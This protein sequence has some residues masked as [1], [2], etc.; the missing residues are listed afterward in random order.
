MAAI[1]VIAALLLWNAYRNT[2]GALSIANI[3]IVSEDD[4]KEMNLLFKIIKSMP[5][6]KGL[7]SLENYEKEDAM[8]E[9]K[10]GNLQMIVEIPENFV[11]D[12]N[13]MQDSSL[14]LYVPKGDILANNRIYAMLSS[15][16]SLMVTTES[17]ICSMYDGMEYYSYDTTV[18]EMEDE[19]F[20][21]YINSFLNR[22]DFIDIE[23]ISAYGN[24]ESFL[25]YGISIIVFVMAIS[26][27]FLLKSY[28]RNILETERILARSVKDKIV[29]NILKI[30]CYS[31]PYSILGSVLYSFF[32]FISGGL[33]YEIY[34]SSAAYITIF[35]I[36]ITI[37]SFVHLFA[38]LLGDKEGREMLYALIVSFVWIVSLSVAI[39]STF[40]V[41]SLS[42]YALLSAGCDYRTSGA[43]WG[44]LVY[45]VIFMVLAVVFSVVHL[46][47]K[48]EFK[49]FKGK[50]FGSNNIYLNWLRLKL[51]LNLKSF[52]FW[53][54]AA[55]I[56]IIILTTHFL[57]LKSE[58]SN[59][60]IYISN[61]ENE[62]LVDCI[63]DSEYSG[64]EYEPVRNANNMKKEILRGEALAGI[65]NRDGKIILYAP[66]GSYSAVILRE[67]IFP[68][69]FNKQSPNLLR[70]YL[71]GIGL[72]D[73]DEEQKYV[74]DANK[75]LSEDF[76]VS[77]FKINEV[78]DARLSG[79]NKKNVT[80]FVVTVMIVMVFIISVTY[81][82]KTN[83]GFLNSKPIFVRILLV[84]ESG[85]V[86]SLLLAV[87][88]LAALFI[89]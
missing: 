39:N 88:A 36:G 4:S 13:Y 53:L 73:D 84:L 64:F 37:S 78:S 28:S 40:L 46:E 17:A 14:T 6:V 80:G 1:L 76:K 33:G 60:V 18:S 54:E 45:L 81:E 50:I 19:V 11:T 74:L 51:K 67:L 10:K 68:Y 56:I 72:S 87:T 89:I 2:D 21:I 27:A 62:E 41:T 59:R 9:L 30:I 48:F 63:S 75:R 26:G 44:Q 7:C 12:L 29:L 24:F 22:E 83:K 70:G 55:V 61:N 71:N 5:A 77:I 25:Y 58:D 66:T 20:R 23:Y 35:L 85:V 69:M 15:V 31:I 8:E 57:V 42:R 16:E 34:F 65:D 32:C 3:G 49:T 79:A 82:M 38:M 52:V 43:F 86:R 47:S